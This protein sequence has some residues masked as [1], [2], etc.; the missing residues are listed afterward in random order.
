LAKVIIRSI[1]QGNLFECKEYIGFPI[2]FIF[3]AITGG[4]AEKKV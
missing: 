4:M 2:A 1:R 3:E